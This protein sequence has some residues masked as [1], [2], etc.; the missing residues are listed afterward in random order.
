MR[1]IGL[2]PGLRRTGWGIVEVEDNR[3]RH[4][5][6]GV[7]A[8]EVDADIA[9]RL[10]QLYEG[11]AAVL[12]EFQPEEAAVEETLANRNASSTL[13]LGMARGTALLAAARA[14]LPAAEYL[15][16]RVKKAV[17]GTGNAKKEQVAM[18]VARLLPGCTIAGPDSADALAV[19]ICHAHSRQTAR[20]WDAGGV[21]PLGVRSSRAGAAP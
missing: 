12:S 17:V 11:V 14:G 4:I 16:T 6:N 10:M 13:K 20:R 18:M 21:K 8:P 2:D 15:P 19:A 7:V 5:A 1:V 3:L 9:V